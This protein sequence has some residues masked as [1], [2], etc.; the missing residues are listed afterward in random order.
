ME[1]KTKLRRKKYVAR[2]NGAISR[3]LIGKNLND[4][5]I[6]KVKERKD[7]FYFF[8]NSKNAY[9]PNLI[10]ED[11]IKYANIKQCNF[12]FGVFVM[13]NHKEYYFLCEIDTLYINKKITHIHIKPKVKYSRQKLI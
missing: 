12:C 6:V 10:L 8:T 11:L 5:V 2:V 13:K 3:H 4:L 1:K 7:N 9:D